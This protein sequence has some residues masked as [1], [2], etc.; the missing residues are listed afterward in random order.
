VKSHGSVIE[1]NQMFIT[2]FL[3]VS[4]DFHFKIESVEVYLFYRWV[5]YCK[6]FSL[7]E[8]QTPD[9]DICIDTG[10]TLRAVQQKMIAFHSIVRY[11]FEIHLDFGVSKQF[12]FTKYRLCCMF[13]K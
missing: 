1:R 3:V 10:L 13:K 12:C 11:C 2:R 9:H 5:Q 7:V 6:V 4:R 8:D